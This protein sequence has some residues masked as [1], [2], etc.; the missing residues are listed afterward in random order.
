[1]HGFWVSLGA[2]RP[3]GLA[4]PDS[5]SNVPKRWGGG[6]DQT[7]QPLGCLKRGRL[8]NLGTASGYPIGAQPQ[9]TGDK[10]LLGH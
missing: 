10:V 8:C 2:D 7:G 5:V 1:M 6:H 3:N 4:L 9:C